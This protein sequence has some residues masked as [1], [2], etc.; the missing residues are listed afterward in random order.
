MRTLFRPAGSLSSN[1]D[2]VVLS[3]ADAG[4]TYCG[5]HI[6][7]LSAGAERT[8]VLDG[9]EAAVVPLEGGCQLSV[10]GLD[11]DIRLAGRP[12][13]FDGVPD[14][15]YIPVGERLSMRSIEGGRIAVAT[16][17]AEE[18]RAPQ[19][20]RSDEIDISIRGAGSAS[21]RI[22]GLL[23]ADVAGPQRLIVVEVH[24]PAGN[25]SSYPPHKHDEWT[26]S[27]VPLEEIYYFEIDGADGFGF[28]RTYTS[29]G[30]IDETVTVRNGDV[31]LIPRGYHGP[32]VAAPGYDM[33]YLNVMAGPDP[34]R[35][36]MIC[37]DPRYAWVIDTWVDTDSQLGRRET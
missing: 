2:P 34:E 30:Q 5:F 13:V 10:D 37:N 36:W 1:G 29:D 31:F 20:I 24:T 27:E 18:A 28:H 22:T 23:S 4:W 7:E 26:E 19:V 3:P 35:R 16:A 9:V 32:C 17:I 11:T 6:V 14:V 33:Y 12:S 8:L 15:A 21:R 25:W